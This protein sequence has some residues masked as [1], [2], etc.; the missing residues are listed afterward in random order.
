MIRLDHVQ[1]SQRQSESPEHATGS[2][3]KRQAPGNQILFVETLVTLDKAAI[4]NRKMNNRRLQNYVLSMLN[5][6]SFV[7]LVDVH[8]MSLKRLYRQTCCG[9]TVQPDMTSDL[10]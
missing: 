9:Q 10:L 5:I 1:E 3:T 2:R 7:L 6:V 8:T 4:D